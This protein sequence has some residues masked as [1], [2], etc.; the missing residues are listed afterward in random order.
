[1]AG[2]TP[3]GIQCRTVGGSLTIGPLVTTW[4]DVVTIPE[5]VSSPTF[6]NADASVI[7]DS[8]LMEAW[9]QLPSTILP[10]VG[11]P[12]PVWLTTYCSNVRGDPAPGKNDGG[13]SPV[14]VRFYVD[15]I[16]P[17]TQVRAGSVD[18]ALP[19]HQLSVT[20]YQV[21]EI[22][23]FDK[24]SKTTGVVYYSGSALSGE[25]V[26]ELR[27]FFPP[28]RIADI[29]VPRT[30]YHLRITQ[31]EDVNNVSAGDLT[32][33]FEAPVDGV[34]TKQPFYN[35][36]QW[37]GFPANYLLFIGKT[38][39]NGGIPIARVTYDYLVNDRGWNKFIAVY[40][41]KNGYVPYDLK[42][43]PPIFLQAATEAPPNEGGDSGLFGKHGNI[44]GST[45]M[46]GIGVFDML[47]SND[48]NLAFPKIQVP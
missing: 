8:F 30:L 39:D 38:V 6:V 4:T 19:R 26:S 9:A 11:D 22:R 47:D 20:P 40:L 37:Y 23:N 35:D 24:N 41:Q 33:S 12:H 3:G 10:K 42:N 48:F 43:L 14:G 2:S 25:L 46:N 16:R 21:Q 31:Y 13:V 28:F 45:T 15:W 27:K 34:S 32:Q 36:E 29:R 17:T 18:N 44:A 1:M 7:G 5:F